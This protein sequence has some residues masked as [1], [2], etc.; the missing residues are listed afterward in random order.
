[1]QMFLNGQWTDR[2]AKIEVRNPY[3]GDVIDTVPQG[4]AADID[5]A[6]A[7]LVAGAVRMRS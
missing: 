2:P 7:G 4:S 5:A 6:L 3:R 1:M